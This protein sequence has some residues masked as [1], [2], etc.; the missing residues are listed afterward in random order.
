MPLVVVAGGFEEVV[1]GVGE[2]GEQDEG[3][4]AAAEV[5]LL[6]ADGQASVV[7]QVEVVAQVTHGEGVGQERA[8]VGLAVARFEQGQ[9]RA[10]GVHVAF[11]G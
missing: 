11:H 10:D 2:V 1:A 4:V 8:K 5:A 3:E 7:D 9:D 6:D